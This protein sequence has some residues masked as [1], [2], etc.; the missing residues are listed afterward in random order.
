LPAVTSARARS[1]REELGLE[2]SAQQWLD[3]LDAAAPSPG[4]APVPDGPTALEYLE[5]LRVPEED[6]A[7]VLDARPDS[8]ALR[9][10]VDREHHI[11][12]TTM[13]ELEWSWWPPL[14]DAPARSTQLVHVWAFLATLP[15]IRD[16]H[17]SR[18]IPD[19]VSWAT[20]ADLGQNMYENHLLHDDTGL[21][22]PWWIT[23]HF[24]GVIYQLGRLQF[25]RRK[26]GRGDQALGLHIPETGA[27]TPAACDESIAWAH[28]F[29]PQHFPEEEPRFGTCSSWLLD[30]QLADY[31]PEDSNI[32][33]FQRR[34][35]VRPDKIVA[36]NESICRFVFHNR[37]PDLDTVPQETTLQRAIVRHLKAGKTWQSASG[38]FEW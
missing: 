7:I 30:P 33:R 3:G 24:R 17:A 1:I 32:M 5:R 18:R 11:L 8:D 29:F 36:D 15:A 19:E 38:Y 13:G 23:I 35:T 22:V 16:Y 12:A 37:T 10:I 14:H 2:A 27:M 21:D 26:T 9:W 25:E 4:R 28:E 6:V 31:L 34:F 20:L